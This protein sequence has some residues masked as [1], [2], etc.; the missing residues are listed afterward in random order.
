MTEFPVL[1][2]KYGKGGVYTGF[3]INIGKGYRYFS[4]PEE[5]QEYLRAGGVDP[6]TF[7]WEPLGGSTIRTRGPKDKR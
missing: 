7:D 2:Y 4:F 1:K 6:D 5:A 3:G